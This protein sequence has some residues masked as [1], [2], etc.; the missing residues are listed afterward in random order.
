MT[1]FAFRLE[2]VLRW[3][4]AQLD[5]EQ[6][7]LSRLAAECARWDALLSKLQKAQTEAEALTQ[8]AAPVSGAD[9][10]ALSTYREY[11]NQQRKAAFDR[12][13]ECAARMAEQRN[14]L[15]KAR[16]EHRLLEKLRQVRRAEWEIT[17][18]R[19]FEALA[20]ETYLAQWTP[21]PRPDH[22]GV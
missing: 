21:R 16:R 13:Q 17:V 7:A 10:G 15:L 4:Q 12:R 1:S 9:L 22:S 3:R 14:R 2:K 6:F 18:N 19:E 20:T 5:L 8:T 11:L